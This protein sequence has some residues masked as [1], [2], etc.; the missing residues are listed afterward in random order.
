MYLFSSFNKKL[1]V[2]HILLRIT[3]K[4]TQMKTLFSFK[5]HTVFIV[6]TKTKLKKTFPITI[7]FFFGKTTIFLSVSLLF[8]KKRSWSHSQKTSLVSKFSVY[9]EF[10]QGTWFKNQIL[11]KGMGPTSWSQNLV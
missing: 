9:T 2:S 1:G 10:W 3:E 5:R 4:N 7:T 11:G 8:P 6:L